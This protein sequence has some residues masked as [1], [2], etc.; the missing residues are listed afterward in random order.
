MSETKVEN[1][2]LWMLQDEL[3]ISVRIFCDK[4]I[5]I[6]MRSDKVKNGYIFVKDDF[7]IKSRSRSL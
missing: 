1:V 6:V 4:F 5:K 3:R 2:Y 7:V